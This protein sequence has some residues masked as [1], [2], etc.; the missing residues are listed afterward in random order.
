[1][2][3]FASLAPQG[4]FARLRLADTPLCPLV[5]S[6]VGSAPGRPNVLPTLPSVARRLDDP[7]RLVRRELGRTVRHTLAG[8]RPPVFAMASDDDPGWF[9]PQ[10]ATWR[11]HGGGAML[12]GGLR[13][14][15]LQTL[16]PLAMAGVA[17][18]SA[19]KEDP[20][21]RLQ[22]TAAFLAA[23]TFGTSAAAE[24]A[25]A[26]V[27]KV[28]ERVRGVAR[29]GRPYS[30]A[31]PHLVTFVHVTEVDSFLAAHQRYGRDRLSP[32]DADRYVDE[33]AE[34]ARRLGGEDPPTDVASL[35]R[36]LR[37][38]RPELRMTG[39]AREAVWFILNPPL[40]LAARPAYA[41]LASASVGLLP[42]WAQRMLWLPSIPAV[43]HLTVRPA[44]QVMLRV[45][46]WAVEDGSRRR[47]P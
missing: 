4:R 24:Q 13:A 29:D 30:A 17:E 36:W 11:V 44:T 41:V 5:A 3:E 28:H 21:G 12:V 15:L 31:D 19:Y 33:M 20:F 10:S 42:F 35:R 47:S 18:H 34:V 16:H 43:D 14:L 26:V 22:R 40:L 9:G 1:M 25:V 39:Q 27:G 2:G 38:V 8:R 6:P 46:G 45:L 32:A 37:D 23:T 7:L